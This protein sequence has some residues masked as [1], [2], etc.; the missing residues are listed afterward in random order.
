[1][2]NFNELREKTHLIDKYFPFNIFRNTPNSHNILRL[3]WHDNIEIIYLADG[4]AVFDIGGQSIDAV[5]GDIIFVNSG[6]LHSGYSVDNTYVSFYALVFNKS[7]LGSQVPDPYHIKYIAPFLEGHSL[8]PGKIGV[9]DENY[10]IFRTAIENTINEFNAKMPGYEIQ[11]K[12]YL[13]SIIISVMRYYLPSYSPI[14]ND[15]PYDKNIESFKI[16]FSHIKQYYPEKITIE[17]ASQIVNLSPFHFCKTFR[18]ITGRTFI[19]FLNLYRVNEAEELLRST[20]LSVT[21]IAERVGFCNINYFDKVFKEFKRY[22]PSQ[23]RRN[24]GIIKL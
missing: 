17:K 13:Y 12:L 4:H 15:K 7:L 10:N 23:C 20:S 22:S 18:K 2:L 24:N 9:S 16:L 11:I 1:M 5:T 3:H 19:E 6:Q 14:K 21:E 8:F